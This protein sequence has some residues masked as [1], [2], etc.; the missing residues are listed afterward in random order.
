[1]ISRIWIALVLA[2]AAG[3]GPG[4][5]KA[6]GYFDPALG[7][8]VLV[9]GS[10]DAKHGDA[11]RA[12]SWTGQRWE[13]LA[14]A[15]PQNR[16]NAAAAY[17]AVRKKGVVCGGA[18]QSAGGAPRREVAG[19]CWE[20]GPGSWR[21]IADIPPRDHHAMVA[22]TSGSVLMFG[23]IPADR[24]APWPAET[25][26]LRG[27][28]WT[29]VATDGPQGRARTALAYDAKRRQVV[30]FGGVSAP[31]QVF[32]QDT[33]TWDGL[34]W[35]KAADGGP[36]G[37]YAHGMVYDEAAGVVLLYG[38]SA[39]HSGAPLT[40]MWQWDGRR[41]TEI[42]LAGPTPGHRYQPVM[43]YDRARQ[44]TVLYGG[45]SDFKDD[46]WE[47]DGRRWEEIKP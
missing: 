37:R 2:V 25:W 9:G 47:W 33:W 44:R 26:E 29:R 40:D 22:G 23:G 36:R 10:Q 3:H 35:S 18:R 6:V 11:D 21:R 5:A 8:V 20:G 32:L 12:W 28:A 14:E 30:L 16:G 7:R 27:D 31:P 13:L 46:T 1:M 4:A 41:W 38:G 19:D 45:L 43:V 15:G 34:E 17:D 39:A 24:S 42:P